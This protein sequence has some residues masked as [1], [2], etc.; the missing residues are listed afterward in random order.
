MGYYADIYVIHKN[1]TKKQILEF[2]DYFVPNRKESQDGYWIPE[3]SGNPIY[4][5]DNANDLMDFM[6]M[7]S[8]FSNRIYWR[9]LDENSLNKHIM[10]FYNEDGSVV[11]GI[12]REEDSGINLKTNNE[13][14]CLIEMKQFLKSDLGYITYEC[15][16][17]D[18]YEDFVKVVINLR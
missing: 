10:I 8:N 6:E 18:T 9:N 16:S 2:L 15:P 7:N 1:A 5:F 4:E 3:Y 12:S 11:F 14:K 13:D 17:E